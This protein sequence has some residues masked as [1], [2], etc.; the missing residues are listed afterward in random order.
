MMPPKKFSRDLN[1][2]MACKSECKACDMYD[3]E[4]QQSALTRSE[5]QVHAADGRALR[6]MSFG[7]VTGQPVLFIAGAAT[8]CS[9]YFAGELLNQ[10][11][12]RLLTMSRAGMEGSDIDLNRT[13]ESTVQDYKEFVYGALGGADQSIRVVAQSQGSVFGLG[14][15]LAGWVSKLALISPADEVANPVIRAMLP[16]AAT[17][18]PDLANQNPMA[19]AEILQTFTVDAMEAMVFDNAHDVDRAVYAC[20]SF[21]SVYRRALC[22][23]FANDANGYVCDTLIAMKPWHLGLNTIDIPVTIMFGSNDTG[24]SP[25][26]G[27]TL[28]KRI[29]GSRRRL[30]PDAGGALLWTHPQLIL[31]AVAG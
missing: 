11:N 31:D 1:A 14:A 29:P 12:I 16:D 10:A 27:Q 26:H 8:G 6:G 18:L 30:I 28:A 21:R 5:I 19:A 7:P 2:R 22:E 9:M 24:H 13:L 17:K 25:D 20:D 23:G 4:D 15:A 3:R